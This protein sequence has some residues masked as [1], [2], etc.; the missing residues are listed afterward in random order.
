MSRKLTDQP[1]SASSETRGNEN[2]SFYSG[3]DLIRTY[4]T[5]AL[6]P[7][8]RTIFDRYRSDLSGRILE[9]GCGAGRVT[10]NLIGD[11]Q[12]VHGVDV[13]EA[14]VEHCRRHF[15]TASFSRCDM[16]DLSSLGEDAFDVVIAPFNVID[17][18][19][20]AD[21]RRTI[22][23][24][25]KVLAP[26]GLLIMSSHNLGSAGRVVGPVADVWVQLRARRARGIAGSILHLPRRRRNRRRLR[27]RE[28]AGP[29]Y[30]I[31]NDTAHDYS[32]LH[33]YVSPQVQVRQLA[34]HGFGLLECLDLDGRSLDPVGRASDC[35]ELHYVARL[36]GRD[37]DDPRA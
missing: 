36:E 9:V 22:A 6:R 2:A 37:A 33:Y 19:G 21:R 32:L 25:R 1:K 8:E 20:D 17:A 26:G 11:A 24:F 28:E 5:E 3:V 18:V 30:R 31:L 12:S 27:A 14:M 34:V 15:P 10:G 16:R 13:S 29:G 4:S 23:E 35:S 7:V